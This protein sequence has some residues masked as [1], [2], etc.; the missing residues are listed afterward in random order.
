MSAGAWGAAC[1]NAPGEEAEPT[2]S[3]LAVPNELIVVVDQQDQLGEA[4][5]GVIG[6]LRGPDPN[7]PVITAKPGETSIPDDSEFPA[8]AQIVE[9]TSKPE[10]ETVLAL[11]DELQG[12]GRSVDLNYLEPVQ[13]NNG[14]RPVDDPEPTDDPLATSDAAEAA[15]SVAVID[16]T[17]DPSVFDI[18]GNRMIDEDHG[19]GEFVKSIIESYGAPPPSTLSARRRATRAARGTRWRWNWTVGTDGV[20]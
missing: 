13:P 19:H 17:G 4:V 12:D 11:L 8:R 1:P 14:F 6:V 3:I 15:L 2:Q 5:N 18:D 7:N 20:R 9:I 16:S 10:V